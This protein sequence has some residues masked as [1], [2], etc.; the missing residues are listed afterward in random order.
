MMMTVK[1]KH[2][3]LRYTMYTASK[4][5]NRHEISIKM[6]KKKLDLNLTKKKRIEINK[7]ENKN[8][9]I[10]FFNEEY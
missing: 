9:G 6:E 1:N 7:L 3:N 5:I 8:S 4:S 10:H 2:Q